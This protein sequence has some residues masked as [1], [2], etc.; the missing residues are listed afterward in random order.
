MSARN[1]PEVSI[2]SAF[3][4]ASPAARSPSSPRSTCARHAAQRPSLA[5]R[6]PVPGASSWPAS[7][8]AAA[9]QS[10]STTLTARRL[11]PASG[12]VDLSQDLVEW[13]ASGHHRC[14]WTTGLGT[15]P[16]HSGT[17]G[18]TQP[19]EVPLTDIYGAFGHA[20]HALFRWCRRAPRGPEEVHTDPSLM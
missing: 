2:S 3:T 6:V 19:L 11:V 12:F 17:T 4:T 14:H 1:S 20:H 7:C 10:G 15:G 8:S 9:S 18:T 13:F 16:N 5:L